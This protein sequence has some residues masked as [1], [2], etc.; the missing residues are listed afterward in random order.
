MGPVR[1]TCSLGAAVSLLGVV[2]AVGASGTPAVAATTPVPGTAPTL[3]QG[4]ADLGAA[5]VQ[6]LTV[7]LSLP[8]RNQA[9]LTSL[10]AGLTN[11][12]SPNYHQFLTPSAFASRFSPTND[13]VN[14]VTAWA[15]S[16]GLT[17]TSV[18]SNRTLVTVNGTA[19]QLGKAFGVTF[20]SYRMANGQTF[21]SNSQAA[22]VPAALAGDVSSIVGLSTL[23]QVQLA[24]TAAPT[25]TPSF[26]S[27]Y[28]PR[29]FW[30][31]YN[32]PANQTG[33]GQTIAVLAE[34]DLTS[35][36][37]DLATFEQTYGLPA[38]PWTT[39]PTGAAS[40]DTS[41]NDEWDLDTQYSTGLAGDVSSLLVYDAPS[42]SNT[43]I[44]AETNKW[45]TDDQAKQANF[46]AGE[47]EL[48]ADTDGFVTS[49]DQV[50]EQGV[51]Q[52][53]TL[54]TAAGDTG[55]FCPL[56]VGVNGVPA[57]L[58]GVNYPAASPYAVGV[59]GTT[60]LGGPSPLSE[61]GWYA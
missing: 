12:S 50:L 48:L 35:P 52:G 14:A 54:F 27:S 49:N 38:V 16:A 31:F 37:A 44:L 29:D 34:G 2:W 17:T 15:S 25:G 40:T 24:P 42:L 33:A 51:A 13:T 6:P 36:K 4:A 59:G 32:A 3:V 41:G 9:G 56:L 10:I 53:Q 11:P 61:I 26:P 28:G 58:P 55:A 45:V 1:R 23:G 39:V 19:S 30:S 21:V 43:D 46:S 5:T 47:C 60:I 8:L 20:H 18:S 22:T 57:G 7:T